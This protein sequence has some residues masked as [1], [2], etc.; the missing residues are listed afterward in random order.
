MDTQTKLV[1]TQNDIETT[2]NLNSFKNVNNP[3]FTTS[4]YMRTRLKFVAPKGESFWIE[5]ISHEAGLTLKA[6]GVFDLIRTNDSYIPGR[7]VFKWRNKERI[8]TVGYFQVTSHHLSKDFMDAMYNAL[9]AKSRGITRNRHTEVLLQNDAGDDDETHELFVIFNNHYQE[10]ITA[11]ANIS[12]NPSVNLTKE[13]QLT[14]TSK[15]PTEKS[16]KWLANVGGRKITTQFYEPRKQLD[17]D[18][19]ENQLLKAM[20]L[21]LG[22]KLATVQEMVDEVMNRHAKQKRELE[23]EINKL[24][25]TQSGVK[26]EQNYKVL[27]YDLSKRLNLCQQMLEI[28]QKEAEKDEIAFLPIK[29]LNSSIMS[30]TNESWFKQISTKRYVKLTKKIFSMNH[31]QN[32]ALFYQQ[33]II[34]DS[35]NFRYPRNNTSKLFEYFALFLVEDILEYY[36]FFSVGKDAQNP[37]DERV[38]FKNSS[39]FRIYLSYDRFVG[40]LTL[41]KQ[42]NKAQLVSVVGGSRRP[43]LMLE[44]HDENGEFVKVFIIE[45]KYR[46]LKNIYND[47]KNTDVMN[48]LNVYSTFKYF[49]PNKKFRAVADVSD[50]AVVYPISDDSQHFEDII[51][52]YEFIPLEPINFSLSSPTFLPLIN[53]IGDFLKGIL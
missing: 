1:L 2:I 28:H 3:L 16:F 20:L 40:D 33:Y 14:S 46:R 23:T 47:S 32:L 51:T 45:V 30:L 42:E 11:I 19:E 48:Q 10:L 49:V 21:K 4:E 50:V 41:A 26:D 36:G 35:E 37:S 31:Y 8:E 53:R 38:L 39:G 29:L 17:Y 7:F 43:D 24:L 6:G 18:T 12:S 25:K 44:L 9:E 22:Q 34:N 5:H 27:N 13:Y 15:K 52:G